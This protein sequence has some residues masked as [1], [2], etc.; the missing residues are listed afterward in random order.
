MADLAG[1]LDRWSARPGDSVGIYLS[2]DAATEA[3]IDLVRLGRG[4]ERGEPDGIA[5]EIVEPVAR[6]SVHVGAQRTDAGS[7]VEIGGLARVDLERGTLALLAQPW[8]LGGGEQT[9]AS[10]EGSHDAVRIALDRNGCFALHAGDAIASTGCRARLRRWIVAV[11]RWT[12]AWVQLSIA[13]AGGESLAT[14]R[15][16]RSAGGAPTRGRFDRLLLAGATVSDGTIDCHFDGRLERPALWCENIAVDD[17]VTAIASGEGL[18]PQ[19]SACWDFARQMHGR[20]A[21]DV[22][23]MQLHGRFCQG[24]KRAVR[25][26]R[27]RGDVFDW[28]QAPEQYSAVHFH[29]DDLIDAGW[30]STARIDLPSSLPSGAYA[31]R[32]RCADAGAAAARDGAG[33]STAGPITAGELR[34]PLFVRARPA[35]GARSP[36]AQV[37]VVFPTFTYLAYGNDR[38][39]LHGGNPE[40][41]A[42]RA[43]TLEPTDVLLSRHPEWGLSLYD[44]HRDGS[45]VSVAS[46]WRPIPNLQPDQRF[47]QAGE[48]SGRWNYS[49][50]LLLVEWL[51]REGIGWHALTDEDVHEQGAAALAPYRAVL[52]GNHPEYATPRMIDAYR[53][54]LERG[55]RLMYLGGN[56]FYWKIA[57]ADGDGLAG[58]IELRRAEDGNRSWAEEPGEYYHAFDATYGG[59]WRRNGITPQSWLGVGYSGQG[60]RRSTG[61]RRCADGDLPQVAY[62]FD[63][64]ADRDFG[65][66]G[67][68]GGG[69]AGI[70]VD[71][72]DESLGSDPAAF[73][74][75]TSKP[76]DATY[77]VANEEILV[78]RPTITGELSP[79][80]RSDVV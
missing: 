69:C 46:R 26:A 79:S 16:E 42:A 70:E 76:F 38:C 55:G 51:E 21:I 78:S 15:I 36:G 6:Q 40:V 54:Y 77:L 13:A 33:A 75:A 12:P 64:V 61:Y 39:A 56:G 23:P 65:D 29:S 20:Q 19:A 18:P 27:W 2:S 35:A 9:L 73:V 8:A 1:Y 44:T 30:T 31:V 24:P 71:R 49:G 45:G 80:V 50:D 32:V 74:L 3:T 67:A 17:A 62:A 7:W 68:I 14:V 58:V 72:W 63:G 60:F 37:A 53:R 41:L 22:G 25:G 52:T 11:V 59:L 48:G 57:C 47:W 4:G 66:G 10:L 28:R 5:F 34:L 43:I